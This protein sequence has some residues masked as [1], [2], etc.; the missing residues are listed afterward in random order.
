MIKHTA[1]LLK[2]LP[3]GFWRPP[4]RFKVFTYAASTSSQPSFRA[5]SSQESKSHVDHHP[6]MRRL[7]TMETTTTWRVLKPFYGMHQGGRRWQRSLFP[8]FKALGFRQCEADDC[9]FAMTTIDD[10]VYVSCY[11]DDLYILYLQDGASSLYAS[12]TR[13]LTQRWKM[14]DE[15]EVTYLL[16]K[17]RNIQARRLNHAP[18]DRLH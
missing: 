5:T 18:P 4:R 3:C 16:P 8:W 15:G 14:E 9:V 10:A 7:E 12:F 2:Q 1:P 13:E 11:V 17:H 6:A